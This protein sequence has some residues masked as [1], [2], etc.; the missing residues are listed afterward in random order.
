MKMAVESGLPGAESTE[1]ARIT[2][3]E[4]LLMTGDLQHA[5]ECFTTALTLRK[6]YPY[7]EA[8]LGKLEK[9]KKNYA[10]AIEHTENAIR[11]QS[12]VSFIAQLAD[13]YALKGDTKKAQSIRKDMYTAMLKSEKETGN[14]SVQHNGSREMAIACLQLGK[15]DDAMEFA[16]KDLA[17]RPDNIAANELMAWIYFL[18]GNYKKAGVHSAKMLQKNTQDPTMLFKAAAISSKNNEAEK[19]AALLSA[20]NTMAAGI[21]PLVVIQAGSQKEFSANN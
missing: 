8:G 9:A 20:A 3:G 13:I 12:E 16:K 1:W 6:N 10:K 5:E 7:A 17:M 15:M 14:A 19:A 21:D 11:L 4:L 2:L 18:D